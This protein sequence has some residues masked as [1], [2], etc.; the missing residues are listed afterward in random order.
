[1]IAH[2]PTQKVAI[3]FGRESSGLTNAELLR[4]HYHVHIP[5]VESFSSL[6][7]SQ[8]IQVVAYELRLASLEDNASVP[9]S[10]NQEPLATHEQVS[11]FHQHL[12]ETMNELGIL[13]PGRSDT[14]MSRLRLLF[15][16]AH[17]QERE[18][19]ILRGFLSAVQ[20]K[21]HPKSIE[22]KDSQ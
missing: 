17:L 22:E 14:L 16:R 11:G 21:I 8:A 4:C 19:H 2:R 7:L 12:Y 3:V 1:M 20:N 6:N 10:P 13:S 5:T 18:V 9:T 15:N